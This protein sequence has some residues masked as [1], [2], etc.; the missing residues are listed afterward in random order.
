MKHLFREKYEFKINIRK[1]LFL[2][3]KMSIR[4]LEEAK[5]YYGKIFSIFDKDN[6]GHI[7]FNEFSKILKKVDP[8]KSDWKIHAIF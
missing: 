3:M 7:E 5:V 1:F 2:G 6:D 4:F 8:N